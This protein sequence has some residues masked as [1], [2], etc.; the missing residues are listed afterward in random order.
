MLV[1]ASVARASSC[2]WQRRKLRRIII[3]YQGLRDLRAED[4]YLNES[5]SHFLITPSN[6]YLYSIRR[7]QYCATVLFKDTGMG[8]AGRELLYM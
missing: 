1:A 5:I 6:S 3:I 7:L 8:G 4:A 2:W